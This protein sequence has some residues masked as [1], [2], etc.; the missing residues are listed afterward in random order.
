M[1]SSVYPSAR[2]TRVSI[3]G[4]LRRIV[5]LCEE[6]A[7]LSCWG[8]E[9]RSTQSLRRP[10]LSRAL[11]V[12]RDLVVDM[13]GLTFADPSLMLDLAM[14]ARSACDRAGRA[15]RVRG[16]APQIRALIELVGLHRLRGVSVERARVTAGTRPALTRRSGARTLRGAMPLL[17]LLF[18]LVPI[19]ELWVILQVGQAIGVL[20]TIA[21]L[22][23]DS[24]SALAAAPP[25]PPAWRALQ[26]G[27]RRRAVAA[28]E[29]ADGALV[30]FGGALLMTPGFSPTSSG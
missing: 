25:G 15:L 12:E 7:V 29:A 3:W 17:V 19:V 5:S 10:A 13:D 11:A 22:I 8:D 27:A 24:I 20:P 28:R 18:I 4:T 21:L 6:T 30:I 14:V 1:R 9:D 23:I 2:L 26:R 16:A